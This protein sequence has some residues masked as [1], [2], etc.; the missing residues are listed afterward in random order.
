MAIDTLTPL[1]QR[2]ELSGI[3]WETYERLLAEL[4]DRRLRL[5]YYRGNLEIMAPSPEHEF[6]KKIIGRF[7]ETLAEELKV[8]IYPL[9]STTFKRPELSGVEPDECFYIQNRRSVQGKKR[10]D[11][12]TDPPPDL[13]IEIDITSS[14][15]NRLAVYADLEVLEVW[16]YDG[17]FLKIYQLQ[18]RQY[19][20]VHESL[21]FPE[22]AITE[23][24][25]F[26]Q[27]A[28]DAN[29]DYL[30]LIRSFRQWI[31]SQVQE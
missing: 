14:S 16:R 11:L 27:Q 8:K 4:R 17:K 26:L 6:Y 2:I 19:I 15:E 22:I 3:S 1:E 31:E 29:I 23:I 9:G 25:Q 5:T 24:A 7:V 13:V 20:Q 10:L 21:A 12:N 30:D 28:M 18:N